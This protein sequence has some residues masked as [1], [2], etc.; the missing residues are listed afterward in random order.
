MVLHDL[1]EPTLNSGL[2][3][4][5]ADKE[6]DPTDAELDMEENGSDSVRWLRFDLLENTVTSDSRSESESE[7]TKRLRSESALVEVRSKFELVSAELPPFS[8]GS[9][10]ASSSSTTGIVLIVALVS[11]LGLG[12]FFF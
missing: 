10:G 11:F 2:E 4:L 12:R 6:T 9:S 1:G 7:D 8:G 3:P 5:K